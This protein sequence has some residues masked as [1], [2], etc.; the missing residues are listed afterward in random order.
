[1]A[2]TLTQFPGNQL[3]VPGTSVQVSFRIVKNTIN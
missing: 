1:M 3:K 2:H